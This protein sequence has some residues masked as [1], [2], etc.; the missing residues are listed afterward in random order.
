MG[1]KA[2]KGQETVFM[3]LEMSSIWIWLLATQIICK[4]TSRCIL[5]FHVGNCVDYK[6]IFK[7]LCSV[8]GDSHNQLFLTGR[9]ASILLPSDH[10]SP[11]QLG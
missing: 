4:N 10:F 7:S 3:G 9:P 8:H 2:G 6:I 1:V 11:Q 5:E